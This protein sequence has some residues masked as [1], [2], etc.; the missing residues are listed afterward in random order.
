M[1]KS[2]FTIAFLLICTFAIA[3]V[4]NLI[5]YQAVARDLSGNPLVSTPVTVVFE[6]RQDSSSGS[7]VY[8]ET[9]TGISTNQ[10]GLFNLEIGGGNPITGSF[11]SINWSTGLYYLQVTV[12]GDVMP[13]TQLLSVPFA[14][15]AKTATSG[16]PGADG[17]NSIADSIAE[18]AG[19]N[20]VNGGY[21]IKMGTDLN[22][23]GTLQVGEINIMYYICNGIDGANGTNGTNGLNGTNGIGVNWL[24]SF[25]TAPSTPSQNDAYYNS[26]AGIS[27][28]WDGATWNVLAQD[29]A[30]NTYTAGTGINVAGNVITNTG[31]LDPNNEI[32][33]ISISNDTVYLSGGGY[34]VLPPSSGDNWGGQ[35]VVTDT[36]LIGAGISGTPLSVNLNIIPTQTSQ[37]TNN[38]GF[39][40]SPNDADSDPTNEIQTLSLINGDSLYIS[41]GNGVELNT[42]FTAGNGINISGDS[43][44]NIGDADNDPTNEIELPATA[45][46]SQ[47]LTWNGTAWVAQNAGSGAD[48]WG[49]QVVMVDSLT[50]FGDGAGTPLSGFDGQYS[51]LSGAP[52]TVSAFANDVPYLTTFT[53]VDGSISNE[54]QTLS[55]TSPSLTLSNGGGTINL[56]SLSGPTYTAGTGINLAGNVITNTAPDQTVALNNGTG[57]NITGTYPNFTINNT[58]AGTVTSVG[59]TAPAQFSVTGS[60][61]T[62]SG[63]LGV[64]WIS[65]AAN[66]VLAAPNAVAG[67]PSFRTLVA[68]DI[69]N[70]PATK[71]TTGTLPLARGGSNASLT[72]INGG[73][74]YSTATAMAITPSGAVGQVLQSNGAAAPTW[75]NPVNTDNQNLSNT[76]SVGSVTINITGG[77]GTT[78]SIDDGDPNPANELVTSFGVNGV[79]LELIEAGNTWNVPLTSLITPGKWTEVAGKLYPTTLT[80]NVGIGTA[81]PSSPLQVNGTIKNNDSIVSYSSATNWGYLKQSALTLSNNT[82]NNSAGRLFGGR[83][84]SFQNYIQLAG[85]DNLGNSPLGLLVVENG[86]VGINA[87]DPTQFLDVNGKIRMRPGSGIAGYIP[88]SDVSGTMTWTDPSTLGLSG[89]WSKTGNN[90]YP[91]NFATESVVVGANSSIN[92]KFKV[93]NN[94]ELISV[95]IINSLSSVTQT[96]GLTLANN[97]TGTGNKVGIDLNVSGTGGATNTGILSTVSNG[98]QNNIAFDGVA[99]PGTST[100][101]AG[102]FKGKIIGGTGNAQTYGI[103]IS[104][105]S[106]STGDA[107]G[108]YFSVSSSNTANVYSIRADVTSTAAN[109]YGFYT[110]MNAAGGTNKYGI[111][112]FVTGGTTNWAGYFAGGN[113]YVNDTLAIGTTT[114]T[115][116]L[117]LEGS[118]RL[119]NL[120]GTAPAIG[121]VLTSMDAFG[122]A[123]W[124]PP[125]MTTTYWSPNGADIYNSNIGNVGIGTNTPLS[126]LHIFNTSNPLEVILENGGGAFKTGYSIK[127]GA[128]QKWFMGKEVT[129]DFVIKD[130]TFGLVRLDISPNGNVG[131]GTTSANSKLNV[132]GDLGLNDGTSEL[133]NNA[134]TVLLKNSGANVLAGDIV[135]V[136][137][138]TDNAFTTTG[139]PGHIA[140]IG[141]AIENINSGFMG[142]IAIAGVATVNIGST[143]VNRGQHC[144][145]SGTLGKAEGIVSPGA[146]SSIGVYISYGL[147]NGTAKVLL[148]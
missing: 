45:V 11:A 88:V 64:S 145:T 57:I 132:N 7:V 55:F 84:A 4:P 1:K 34:I 21:L 93:F 60:P 38:S 74:V 86:F 66:T 110:L 44:I 118:L 103:S 94:S 109:Q 97:G 78:F 15:H 134:I 9:H 144:I 71:I 42:I 92:T 30:T 77:T 129:P 131:I 113:V 67:T 20:C 40:T 65:Q 130:E 17:H 104:N 120:S 75:V 90:I 83:N 102:I 96:T 89:P 146:G 73:I 54:L 107:Y 72:A 70:L 135:I 3:Q 49:S 82:T 53:E 122:N 12:N 142:K 5:N 39:I 106:N 59:L 28:I 101:E 24:G 58:S 136:D 138:G 108:G 50:I 114:P 52:T 99:Y 48:N 32:Q 116:K 127:T 23:D 126:K 79:N 112:S 41:G 100:L 69:P 61:I 91:T 22:D 56:S 95:D 111:Y 80:N 47:V 36:T 117:H 76:P 31:D 81:T 37:L 125:A 124:A 147:A 141:V 123:E 18:P 98:T 46:A 148:R 119:N 105:Q 26:T 139:T 128:G 10:F 62:G 2:I 140:A 14:L 13:S 115:A 121:S 6:I 137:A 19:T 43:I 8:A 16:V 35:T 133:T 27:Y 25:T 87:V 29:G 68:N 85:I 63:T 33:T 51:S 143:A